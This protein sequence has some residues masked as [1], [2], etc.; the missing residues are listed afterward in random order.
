MSI[1][2]NFQITGH[3][4]HYCF[5][6][7]VDALELIM[8]CK[9][10]AQQSRNEYR[11]PAHYWRTAHVVDE[12]TTGLG[13]TGKS[14]PIFLLLATF[15]DLPAPANKY[16]NAIINKCERV[17]KTKKRRVEVEFMEGAKC[18]WAWGRFLGADC[19]WRWVK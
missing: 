5:G 19:R 15:T 13:R 3:S 16:L 18:I 9:A 6:F 11:L 4:G 7:G 14:S 8:Q 2:Q 17:G 1:A 12:P 10:N